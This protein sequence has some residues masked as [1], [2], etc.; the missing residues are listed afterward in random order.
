MNQ[1]DSRVNPNEPGRVVSQDLGLEEGLKQAKALLNKNDLERALEL[2]TR[3][4]TGFIRGI[5]LFDCMG[6]VLLRQG[7]ALEGAHYKTLYRVLQ[8]TFSELMKDVRDFRPAGGAA[9]LE[10]ES[11]KQWLPSSEPS[12][13]SVEKDDEFL[14]VTS[15]M[16]HTFMSQ[17]HFARALSIFDRLLIQNPDDTSVREAREQALK[18]K[19]KKELLEV[20]QR[21]LSTIEQMKSDRSA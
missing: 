4:E 13:E 12:R 1:G 16:A 9:A 21:W 15:A 11:P 6:E 7:N 17:G 19:K 3:L 20:L 5:E 8:G 2:L 14:P 18:K 10:A